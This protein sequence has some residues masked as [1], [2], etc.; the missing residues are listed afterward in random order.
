MYAYNYHPL[1]QSTAL[2]GLSESS[3]S[4]VA[5]ETELKEVLP[6]D[7]DGMAGAEERSSATLAD[8]Q[9]LRTAQSKGGLFASCE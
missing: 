8:D 3:L 2:E 5:V 6:S 4:V 1:W 7:L 9:P